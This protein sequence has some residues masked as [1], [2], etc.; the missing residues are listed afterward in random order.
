MRIIVVGLLVLLMISCRKKAQESPSFKLI[1]L[2]IR[3][4]WTNTY[5]LKVYN[6]GKTYIFNDRER[7]GER[8]FQ[9]NLGKKEIDSISSLVKLILASNIDTLYTKSCYECSHYNLIIKTNEGKKFKSFVN[10]VDHS[11]KSIDCM[12]KLTRY[13]Y[14]IAY[15]T[16]NSMDTLFVFESRRNEFYPPPPPPLIRSLIKFIPSK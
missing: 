12:N 8:Y 2:S 5:C 15:N 3:Y 9:I 7:A 4:G 14:E 1:D 10:G 16:R 13:L 11:N 6:N